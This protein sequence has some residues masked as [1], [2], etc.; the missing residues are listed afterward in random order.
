M[1]TK[2]KIKTRY[3]EI[4]IR[5]IEESP[6][7]ANRQ[8]EKTFKRLVENIK[9]DGTLTSAIL[10]MEKA[11]GKYMCISGHHRVKAAIKAKLNKVPCLIIPEVDRSTQIRLQL[12]HND[13][14][15]E[16]DKNILSEILTELDSEDYQ[17]LSDEII[18]GE[19]VQPETIDYEE[20]EFIYMNFCL[21]PETK[22]GFD[23][24]IEELT[25]ETDNY[26]IT[27]QDYQKFKECLT[28]AFRS[29]FKSSGYALSKFIEIVN[30]HQDEII[31][32]PKL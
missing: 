29:G 23:Q 22:K 21:L 32:L 1:A 5:E 18:E 14:K 2:D 31:K 10:V 27:Y 6:L 15:G 4:N 19:E 24:V 8:D 13:I 20:K 3:A 12:S 11:Q 9:K 30:N 7:N 17:Y 25:P 16:N 28:I 26:F